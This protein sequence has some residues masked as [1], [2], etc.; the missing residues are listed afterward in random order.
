MDLKLQFNKFGEG[1]KQHSPEILLVSGLIEGV[2]GTVLACRA[3]VKLYKKNEEEKTD[4]IKY[5]SEDGLIKADFKPD[6]NKFSTAKAFD[7]CKAYAPSA[8]VYALGIVSVCASHG[9]M[10]K[11]YAGL[12]A[13]Y[14]TLTT[15]F[16]EYRERVKKELG[17]KKEEE[18][19]FG[20]KKETIPVK[21][22][23]KDGKERTVNK[24]VDI[25]EKNGLS[26]YAQLLNPVEVL[27]RDGD[28]PLYVDFRIVAEENC[29]N[30]QLKAKG[31][32]Y[33]NDL[34]KSLGV[35]TDDAGQLAGWIYDP[36]RIKDGKG[37]NQI[38]I[39][40]K[41]IYVENED[42]TYDMEIWLDYNVDGVIFGKMSK[43][44]YNT[45]IQEPGDQG[46]EFSNKED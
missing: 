2:V 30:D 21:T 44:E 10:R 12:L 28:D 16:L 37:D 23:T 25:R 35:E 39:I 46:I 43:N 11:R 5:T 26:P 8:A 29:A 4:D 7:I 17:E 6:F 22:T 3:A 14:A 19:Y 13:S 40:R 32:L 1:L 31:H 18:L 20:T 9:I 24:K 41:D 36:H 34:R 33:L 42:G 15:S 38:K 45:H 27:G